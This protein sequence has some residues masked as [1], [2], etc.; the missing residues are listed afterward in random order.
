MFL[1]QVMASGEKFENF[2]VSEVSSASRTGFLRKRRQTSET[3]LM[4][5]RDDCCFLVITFGIVF[6]A[7][8]AVFIRTLARPIICGGR[9]VVVI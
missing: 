7:D 2:V 1:R 9:I 5:T 8:F 3:G 4:A 6:E